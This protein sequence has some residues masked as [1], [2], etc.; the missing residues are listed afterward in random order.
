MSSPPPDVSFAVLGQLEVTYA[1]GP[2]SLPRPLRRAL[3]AL[4]LVNRNQALTV[5]EITR[6][7]WTDPAPA[8]ARAQVHA[9]VSAVRQ[10][11]SDGGD[12]LRTV[13]GGYRL[14]ARP[15]QLDLLRFDNGLRSARSAADAGDLT[16]AVADYRAAIGLWRGPALADITAP[17]AA[18]VRSRLAEQRLTAYEELVEL[19]LRLGR[20]AE[21]V[22]DLTELVGANPLRERIR[23]Q[24][25]LALYRCGRRP[26]AL[27]LY[28]DG[29]RVLAEAH[30]LDPSRELE[31]LAQQILRTDQRL[32]RPRPP[33]ATPIPRLLPR[34]V[35]HFTGRE[36][37]LARLG[38]LADTASDEGLVVLV[39]GPGGI[40]KTALAVQWADREQHRFPDGQLFVDLRG[41]GADP[42]LAVGA[43]DALGH[44]LRALGVPG[45]RHPG[46]VRDRSDLYQSLVRDRRLVLVLD[47][48]A[49]T[50]QV[51]PLLPA[52]ARCTVVI[53][54]RHQLTAL[55]TRT[56]ARMLPLDVLDLDDGVALLRRVIGAE[57][58]DEEPDA[59]AELVALCGGMPL[60][61]RIAA[62]KLATRP[63]HPVR[64]L[65][66]ELADEHNRLDA[67]A[68][69]ETTNVRAA[70]A[71]SYRALPEPAR[72][73]FRL[74]GLHPGPDVTVE[75][76]AAMSGLG[77]REARAAL[78]ALAAA[79]LIIETGSGRRHGCHDLIR[80]YAREC[81]A[82]EPAAGQAD[83][84]DRLVDRYLRGA[85]AANAILAPRRRQ[86]D[87]AIG[88]DRPDLPLVEDHPAALAWLDGEWENLDATIRW[89]ADR[90]RS[91]A[92]WQLAYLVSGYGDYRGHHRIL[93]LV[94]IGLTAARAAGDET[95]ESLMLN[96]LAVAS[97]VARRFDE[98]LAYLHEALALRRDQHD[99]RGQSSVWNNLGYV[100]HHLR[101]FDEAVDAYLQAARLARAAEDQADLSVAL[102]NL[103]EVYTDLGRS[104]QGIDCFRQALA[105]RRD[106]GDRQGEGITLAG[107]GGV[108]LC[109]GD[110]PEAIRLL[111]AAV[112]LQSQLDDRVWEISSRRQLGRAHLAAGDPATAREHF[113]RSHA[114]A[115]AVHHEHR[116][117]VSLTDIAAAH[118]AEAAAG[119]ET[120][121]GP[122]TAVAAAATA[123]E[124]CLRQAGALRARNPDSYEEA[125]IQHVL[126][127]LERLRGRPAVA[128]HH[129]Q[130]AIPLYHRAGA[131][132]DVATLTGRLAARVTPPACPGH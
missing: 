7:L 89:A 106:D 24:L 36:A 60:A 40:G 37:E 35:G 107:L 50:E 56:A 46:D 80:L 65:V 63:R 45:D 10:A 123:A 95:G 11:L 41:H 92:A 91:T 25:M 42:E 131:T 53:T 8:T 58:A 18:P 130:R 86:L 102:S 59:C 103:G 129:W 114:L 94:A 113:E 5:D 82:T 66:A 67:L 1:G 83:A 32:D 81:A 14:D 33:S 73:V 17:F 116:A 21:L 16:P 39:T 101:R 88:F 127:D 99:V 119:G 96:R 27:Q 105:I 3:L 34:P 112:A 71:G 126:G 115:V 76:V 22:A 110:L 69:D 54:S 30:G 62:A 2:V 48:A 70:F 111:E 108:Y 4:L 52:G 20:D 104:E 128:R 29:R 75:P 87:P 124:Q 100:L 44:L 49:T 132:E 122:D 64:N 31:Q 98:A 6:G 19:E 97:A 74:L 109:R 79:H 78:D 12:A 61:V 120:E 51:L 26:E 72:R 84:I 13:P 23:R 77:L 57:R 9:L 55:A 121:A 43:G 47:N 85:A 125:R 68:V 118:L 15:H 38:A 90:G 93:G 28:R 117:A